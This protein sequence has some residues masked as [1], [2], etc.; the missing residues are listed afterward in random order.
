VYLMN[1]PAAPPAGPRHGHALRTA[2]AALT[3]LLAV[4]TFA[5]DSARAAE[6]ETRSKR[7]SY[8][9]LNL[10]SEA[11]RVTLMRRV[12]AAAKQVCDSGNGS[13][14]LHRPSQRCVKTAVSGA[15][16]QI[17]SKVLLAQADQ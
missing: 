1:A 4:T 13:L 16:A 11:G 14:P 7:V 5:P 12:K 3:G 6:P 17:D 9:D 8:A 10:R 15:L 2:L